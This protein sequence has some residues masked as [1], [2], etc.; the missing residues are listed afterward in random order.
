MGHR[1]LKRVPL[2]F[3]WP[4]HEDWKG[5]IP[6]SYT[7]DEAIEKWCEGGEGGRYDPPVGEGYQLWQS[8]TEGSPISP[9]FSSAEKL[10]DWC[11]DNATI[12]SD[13][14]CTKE[15]WLEMFLENSLDVDS[16]MVMKFRGGKPEYF[17][18]FANEPGRE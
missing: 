2:D 14:T 6:P 17:G 16:M 1:E 10:A 9:V 18:S 11:E 8:V 7:D 5:Y 15:R 12:F 13:E 4:L 3:D